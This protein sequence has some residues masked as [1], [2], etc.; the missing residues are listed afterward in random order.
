MMWICE[1]CRTPHDKLYYEEVGGKDYMCDTLDHSLADSSS[2]KCTQRGAMIAGKV[3]RID[4]RS[5]YCPLCAKKS[6][7]ILHRHPFRE[8]A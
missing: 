6:R 7:F 5:Y 1:T 4:V 8:A 3:M 2:T